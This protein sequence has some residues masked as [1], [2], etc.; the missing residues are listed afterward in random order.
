MESKQ[1]ARKQIIRALELALEMFESHPELKEIDTAWPGGSVYGCVKAA[2]ERRQ[3]AGIV[4]DDDVPYKLTGNTAG[5]RRRQQVEQKIA[6]AVVD[7]LLAADFALGVYNGEEV[8]IH[9]SR[10]RAAI[11]AALFDTDEDYLNVYTKGPQ[12]KWEEVDTTDDSPDHWVRF[13]YG[14]DGWDV[15]SDYCSAA[16]LDQYI[17]EGTAVDKLVE[18]FSG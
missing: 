10:D 9:H 2:Y 8:V 4:K 15:I 5:V 3:E 18:S 11:L 7:T 16:L 6:R 17:G 14:N 1:Q 13:V 12:Q